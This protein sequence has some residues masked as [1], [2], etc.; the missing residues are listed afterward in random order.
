MGSASAQLAEVEAGRHGR[1]RPV[2]G[3]GEADVQAET[4]QDPDEPEGGQ[5]GPRDDAAYGD[6]GGEQFNHLR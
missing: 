5:E 2:L 6:G 3:L 4:A 1:I